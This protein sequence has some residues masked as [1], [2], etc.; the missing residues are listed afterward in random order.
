MINLYES[1]TVAGVTFS[2]EEKKL[3]ELCCLYNKKEGGII[4][5]LRYEEAGFNKDS[6]IYT[7]ERFKKLGLIDNCLISPRGNVACTITKLGLSVGDTLN[8]I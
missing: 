2:E 7:I 8:K 3:I 1:N 6:I 5:E 4:N